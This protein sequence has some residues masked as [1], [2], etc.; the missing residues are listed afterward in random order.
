MNTETEIWNEAYDA[1]VDHGKPMMWEI[2]NEHVERG[3]ISR[4]DAIAMANDVVET[5]NL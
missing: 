3:H 2:L 4:D 1:Y 5:A